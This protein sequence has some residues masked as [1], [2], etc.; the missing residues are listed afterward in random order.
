MKIKEFVFEL[1]GYVRSIVGTNIEDEADIRMPDQYQWASIVKD[2]E[3][4]SLQIEGA[5]ILR[6]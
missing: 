6:N 4:L 3:K 5:R 2:I 1:K